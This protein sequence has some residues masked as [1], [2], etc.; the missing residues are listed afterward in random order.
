MNAH[1]LPFNILIALL[2]ILFGLIFLSME[3]NS[4]CKSEVN[5]THHPF[6][7]TSAIF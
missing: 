5:N 7:I 6:A 3:F 4:I 2:L 1:L